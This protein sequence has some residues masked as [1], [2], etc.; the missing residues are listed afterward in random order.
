MDAPPP[1]PG[2]P[3]EEFDPELPQAASAAANN[4]SPTN[5]IAA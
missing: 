1:G 4:A 5:F 2:P 3:N